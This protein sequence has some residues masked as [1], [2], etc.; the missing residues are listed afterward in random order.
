MHGVRFSIGPHQRQAGRESAS[1]KAVKRRKDGPQLVKGPK[2]VCDHSVSRKKRTC[3]VWGRLAV[4]SCSSSG[5]LRMVSRPF[6]SGDGVGICMVRMVRQ[7][8]CQSHKPV[9]P[10]KGAPLFIY[11]RIFGLWERRSFCR[12]KWIQ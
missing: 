10:R 7:Q 8:M 1:T 5:M 6:S 11:G 2:L 3:S 12:S 4:Q 9:R